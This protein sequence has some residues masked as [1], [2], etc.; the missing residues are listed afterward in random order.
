[1]KKLDLNNA[2]QAIHSTTILENE[3]HIAEGVI[4]EPYCHIIGPV[5]IGKD[6]KISSFCYIRGP[7]KIGERNRINPHC[8]IGTE[9]ESRD[10]KPSGLIIIGNDNA[11]SEFTAIQRGTGDRDTEI[12]DNNFIMDNV[13]ISHDN[14]LGN[15]VTI[16][17]NVV[18]G[19]HT[20]VHDGATIGI[21]S[22]THQ[23]STVGAHSMI[24][25]NSTIT[26]DVPPFTMVFGNPAKIRKWNRYQM[27]KLGMRDPPSGET[28]EKYYS[29]FVTDSRREILD[30]SSIIES[31]EKE[32]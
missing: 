20:V 6:T 17:P 21:A 26:K 22:S 10:A 18:L 12:G 9:P 4:I 25:M 1:M 24:G 8:V 13:H 3:V 14:K 2:S 15:N 30:A 31:R 16:A 27:K 29:H 7:A 5:E 11:I 32:N 19:G 23:F 28:Y